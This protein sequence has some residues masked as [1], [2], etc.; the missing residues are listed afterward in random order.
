MVGLLSNIFGEAG[1]LLLTRRSWLP[2]TMKYFTLLAMLALCRDMHFCGHSVERYCAN[3]IGGGSTG[4]PERVFGALPRR[5][6]MSRR[7]ADERLAD[8]TDKLPDETPTN[9]STK[10]PTSR[11]TS[12]PTRTPT[13]SPTRPIHNHPTRPRTSPATPPTRAPT[14]LPQTIPPT[15]YTTAPRLEPTCSDGNAN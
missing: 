11:P 1:R 14:I 10:T 13:S 15:S 6:R 7:V 3:S 8:L 9:P 12:R 4:H 5:P 2:G